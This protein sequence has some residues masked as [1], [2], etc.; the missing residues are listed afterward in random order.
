MQR[1]PEQALTWALSGGD[2][3][4]L[5]FTVAEADVGMIDKLVAQGALDATM[6]GQI[7][8]VTDGMC[9]VLVDDKRV[10]LKRG[11]DHFDR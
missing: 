9:Q 10:A 8:A 11:F 3:Y 6:I 5:C 7:Q 4:Q 2:D 1:F